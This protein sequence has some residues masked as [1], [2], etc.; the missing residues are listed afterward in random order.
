[1]QRKRML[2]ARPANRALYHT[3]SG[4]VLMLAGH[5]RLR[6]NEKRR[7]NHLA[8]GWSGVAKC[9]TPVPKGTKGS[10]SS[11]VNWLAVPWA[12]RALLEADGYD[13]GSAWCEAV[14]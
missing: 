12:L 2:R 9:P 13:T 10:S 8:T 3:K 1:M 11:G 7:T 4:Q 5:N 14:A 6:I